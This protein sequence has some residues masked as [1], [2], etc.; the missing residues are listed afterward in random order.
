MQ[1]LDDIS[2]EHFT[3]PVD[4]IFIEPSGTE[5]DLAECF[6]YLE[7]IHKHM[8]NMSMSPRIRA[9]YAATWQMIR[10]RHQR[11]LDCLE[12]HNFDANAVSKMDWKK[13]VKRARQVYLGPKPTSARPTQ[14]HKP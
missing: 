7:N 14:S 8:N 1:R 4:P 13:A 6:L 5:W 9:K 3:Y 2:G 12:A 11:L 10:A